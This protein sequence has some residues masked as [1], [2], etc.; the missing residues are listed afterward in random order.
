MPFG[1][2]NSSK[3]FCRWASLWFTS[4]LS[5]F[6]KRYGARAVLSSYVDDAFGGD[7]AYSTAQALIRF[8][9]QAGKRHG[10]LVNVTKTRG[11]A[12]AMVILG[13]LYHSRRKICSLDPAKVAKYSA[14]IS[15]MLKQSRITSKDLERMVGRLEFAAW[16]EPFGRP[17]L[18]FLSAYIT[19]AFPHVTLPLT[20]MMIVCLQVWRLLLTRNRGLHFLFI[21]GELPRMA[22]PLYVDASLTGGIGGYC[23]SRYF[24]MSM[25][26]LKPW[27]TSCDGWSSF[28]NVDIA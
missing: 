16:V 22:H 14:C 20:K 1:K 25:E 2:A 24:S 12:I 7:K 17:L 27:M 15:Q 28:P 11:P 10:T 13:L 18:T 5:N 3:I 19:P 4:C 8:I 21:L 26:Q 23:G 9:T 6:N